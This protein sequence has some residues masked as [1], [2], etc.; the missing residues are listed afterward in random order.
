MAAIDP[1]NW[2]QIL[3]N[4]P[5]SPESDCSY[6]ADRLS[7]VNYFFADAEIPPELQEVA[8]NMGFRRCGDTWYQTRCRSCNLCIGYRVP[9]KDFQ[10]SRNMKTV[11]RRNRDLDVTVRNPTMTTEKE[12]I[13]LRYQYS[14]HYLRPAFI[15]PAANR[16]FDEEESLSIMQY[17]MYTNPNTTLEV[18]FRLGRKLLGFGIFDVALTT[19]SLVYFVFD[20]DFQKRS[21]GTL[22]VLHS[23]QWCA[24]Q[25]FAYTNLG[26]YIPGHMKMA[27]K[28][29]FKPCEYLNRETLEWQSELPQLNEPSKA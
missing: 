25:G 8:I 18:E 19:T 26:Y 24:K 16:D 1:Q 28:G 2:Y 12:A 3:Q 15:R 22:N 10:P 4:L 23:I 17:Q 13:Y 14:Q 21:L 29:R 5:K 6:F 20:P 27:Y 9:A 7:S 11:L